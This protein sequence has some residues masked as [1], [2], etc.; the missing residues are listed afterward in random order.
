MAHLTSL[1]SSIQVHLESVHSNHG[2]TFALLGVNE[3][4]T[5]FKSWID[6]SDTQEGQQDLISQIGFQRA[7]NI[8]SSF[9][10]P[11]V[12]QQ[13]SIP[14]QHLGETSMRLMVR[15][16]PEVI[17]KTFDDTFNHRSHKSNRLQLSDSASRVHEEQD[18]LLPP[19]AQPRSLIVCILLTSNQADALSVAAVPQ[20]DFTT[21]WEARRCTTRGK[22]TATLDG[23]GR[24]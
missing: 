18:L 14:T 16:F 4:I 2:T 12:R 8:K 20:M 21:V 22:Q 6:N 13:M 10:K 7:A 3:P 24:Q 9:S 23:T 17:M 11:E 5:T 1:A 15:A 19:Y